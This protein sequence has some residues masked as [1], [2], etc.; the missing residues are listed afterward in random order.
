M[1]A[2]TADFTIKGYKRLLLSEV[3]LG[4]P[5]I[6]VYRRD[7]HSLDQDPLCIPF[8]CEHSDIDLN[9]VIGI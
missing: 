4:M 8:F 5:D 6:H 9:D 7:V 2:V 1:N 3:N